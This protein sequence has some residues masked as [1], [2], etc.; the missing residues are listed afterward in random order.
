MRSSFWLALFVLAFTCISMRA[1]TVTYIKVKGGGNMTW[2]GSEVVPCWMSMPKNCLRT[3]PPTAT[4]AIVVEY[5]SGYILTVTVE[6][7]TAWHVDNPSDVRTVSGAN[8]TFDDSIEMRID[9]SSIQA[10]VGYT[11]NLAGMT[12]NS[13]GVLTIYIP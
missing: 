8:H 11:V 13:S 4:G 12:T 6:N 7:M 5:G 3:P 10:L 2:V 1:E 9:A